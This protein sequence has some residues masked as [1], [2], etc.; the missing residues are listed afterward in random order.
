[1]QQSLEVIDKLTN[2][3]RMAEGAV[4]LSIAAGVLGF[5]PAWALVPIYGAIAAGYEINKHYQ[6]N[7]TLTHFEKTTI[8]QRLRRSANK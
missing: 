6:K 2:K 7:L 4:I 3:A 1:M 5:W 8:S